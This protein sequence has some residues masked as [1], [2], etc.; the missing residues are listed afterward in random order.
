MPFVHFYD[1]CIFEIYSELQTAVDKGAGP[2]REHS[3][4]LLHLPRQREITTYRS[5]CVSL[6][7]RP[8]ASVQQKTRAPAPRPRH[9]P[10][11]VSLLI[12]LVD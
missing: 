7:R 11:A 2:R 8:T 10:T 5:S 1:F 12:L 4:R 3:G 6:P 9:L